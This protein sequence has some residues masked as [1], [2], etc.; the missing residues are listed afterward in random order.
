MSTYVKYLS[1]IKDLGK[2]KQG[3]QTIRDFLNKIPASFREELI[4]QVKQMVSPVGKAHGST[5]TD[6]INDIFK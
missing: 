6:H 1:K 2:V 5:I 4:S 3:L